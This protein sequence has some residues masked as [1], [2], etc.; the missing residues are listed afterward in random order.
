MKKT[1][2]IAAYDR[3]DNLRMLLNSLRAQLLP[4]DDYAVVVSVDIG[5]RRF[6]DVLKIASSVDFARNYVFQPS[7]HLGINHNTYWLM[8]HVFG[9]FGADWNVYLEDDLVLSPDAFNLVEWY[10]TRGD[11]LKALADGIGAYCL[12]RLR[13]HGDP[14]KVY[15]SRGFCAWGF[16][17]DR[18]QW[19][20][21]GKPA[22]RNPKKGTWDTSVAAHIRAQG[23]KVYNAFPELSRVTNTGRGGTNFGFVKYDEVMR[24][25]IYNQS[26]QKH[27][28]SFAG[29][30]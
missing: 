15:L 4:L 20:R 21:F 6:D 18:H 12:C 5:G 24:N 28:F 23:P 7:V 30:A 9:E 16:V 22:W 1:I 14:G 19:E 29:M 17:M 3:P 13:E 26:R 2:T 27:S 25:H 10:I 11:E 8:D